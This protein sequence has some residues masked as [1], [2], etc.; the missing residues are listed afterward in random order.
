MWCSLS[1]AWGTVIET[2]FQTVRCCFHGYQQHVNVPSSGHARQTVSMKWAK[3]SSICHA[4]LFFF[5][6]FMASPSIIRAEAIQIENVELGI[7]GCFQV[8]AMAPIEFDLAATSADLADIQAEL[9]T[10]DPDGHGVISRLTPVETTENRAHFSA[11]FRSGKI[12]APVLIELKRNGQVIGRKSLRIDNQT[13]YRCL[14]QSDH[15]WLLG[16]DQPAFLAAREE[17]DNHGANQI[18]VASFDEV[19]P[20]LDDSEALETVTLIVFHA[21]TPLTEHESQIL[22]QW[23][24]RG[25]RLVIDI[26]QE[27]EPLQT[28]ALASWLPVQPVGA[29]SIR[30]L[31]A[32][33]Q[34]IPGSGVLRTLSPIAGAVFD[35]EASRVLA[36]G[37]ETP[38]I[39]RAA[40]GNGMVTLLS[41][42]MDQ[43]PLST[44]G[45]RSELAMM[46]AGLKPEW[47]NTQ[48][49]RLEERIDTELNPT[50]VT[51]LQTQLIHALDHYDEVSR[52]S[53]WVVIG[54][55][56]IL[57]L[58]I[59][60]VDY[61][62]VHYLFKKPQLTWLT[63]PLWL[64]AVTFWTFSAARTQNVTQ[65][66][67]RQIEILDVDLTLNKVRSRT[68][69]NFYSPE[70]R[71][72]QIV[73]KVNQQE[74]A[75]FSGP[76]QSSQYEPE[77]LQTSW[78][79]RPETS[80][81]GMYRTGGLE[82]QKP[83]YHLA[84]NHHEIPDLPTR[85]FSTGSI[86]SEWECD[87]DLSQLVEFELLDPGTG[88]LTGQVTYHGEHELSEWF[89]A[90]GNFAYFPRVAKGKLQPPLKPGDQLQMKT[91][92]SNNLRNI[93]IGLT[94]TRIFEEQ[95]E[96]NRENYD[97]LSR[98]PDPILR[99]LTFHDVTGNT[100]YTRLSNQTLR[101]A[102]L[103]ELLMLHRAVLYGR[104]KVPVT[105]FTLNENSVN[106]EQQNAVVR[107]ILPVQFRQI[108]ADAPPDPS[109][110]QTP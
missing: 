63:L 68:W 7:D 87:V 79:D 71:R 46:L 51:D 22:S 59:G 104:I 86:L 75:G 52:P 65:E 61:F 102:D 107:I 14:K 101:T 13:G 25:G 19:F 55:C 47:V 103:S 80:Y 34:L 40:Y 23:V 91:A 9:T 70:T 15:L 62:I 109:L 20:K 21:S 98:E 95:E 72:N 89:I 50:G 3:Q 77:Y 16:G 39:A 43:R 35:P 36:T 73:A 8:G 31:S 94:R 54:W 78:I 69:M 110:L 64:A 66:R 29:T 81:R 88:R 18:H 6:I 5:L 105:D 32:M 30:N 45:A 92:R 60:P 42:R 49:E 97:P 27:I 76:T 10:V 53:Y 28:G 90:Y 100:A 1:A 57:M 41:M 24:S 58:L 106:L 37:I 82:S 2:V 48:R 96:T 56:A 4:P 99:T 74:L 108:N 44:W 93:L 67:G 11:V 38:L 84:T 83:K 85:V 33:N 12:D 26:G 17:I